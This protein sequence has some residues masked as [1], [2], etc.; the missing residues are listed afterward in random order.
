VLDPPVVAP[1]EHRGRS[2]QRRPGADIEP[3]D[4]AMPGRF[5][6]HR[7]RFVDQ[8]PS[9]SEPEDA[10]PPVALVWIPGWSDR[11]QPARVEAGAEP[12]REARP[13]PLEPGREF[14]EYRRF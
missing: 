4:H 7:P 5:A 8:I 11:Y 14:P 6:P 13:V 1:I 2:E 9:G 3:G 10:Y 12:L